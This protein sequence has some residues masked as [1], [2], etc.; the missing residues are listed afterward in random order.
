MNILF[1]ES[2][3]NDY[4]YWQ[5][6]D[7]KILKRINLLLKECKRQPFAGTGKPEPLR[8]EMAGWLSRRV[9]QEHRLVYKIEGDNV[10]V[11]QCR[12]HY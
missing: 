3:W 12:Y 2:A 9:D 7:K 5:S 10:V 1:T 8:F 11:L 4:V 6:L